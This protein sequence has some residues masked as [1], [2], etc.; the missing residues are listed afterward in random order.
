MVKSDALKA[1]VEAITTVFSIV[2]DI[3]LTPLGLWSNESY[4]VWNSSTVFLSLSDSCTG[5]LLQLTPFH[6]SLEVKAGQYSSGPV[7]LPLDFMLL[8]GRRH[9]DQL[10]KYLM[11]DPLYC[12]EL[13]HQNQTLTPTSFPG[14]F[15]CFLE[16]EKGPWELGWLKPQGPEFVLKVRYACYALKLLAETCM[17]RRCETSFRRHCTVSL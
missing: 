14:S 4:S 5:K 7:V 2:W 8:A 12:P 3:N 13:M 9:C 15:L 6:A 16:V 11:Y 1:L 17:Q 10:Y